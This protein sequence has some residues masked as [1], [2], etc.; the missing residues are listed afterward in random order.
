M[1]MKKSVNM[2]WIAAAVAGMTVLSGTAM[3]AFADVPE[4]IWEYVQLEDEDDNI[5]YDFKEVE[6]AVPQDWEGKYKFETSENQDGTGSSVTFYHPASREAREKEL[7]Y[8][9]EGGVLFSVCYSENYDFLDVLPSYQ[10]IGSGEKGV[11]YL[12]F[13]TDVQGYLD[14]GKIWAEWETLT[15]DY[16]WIEARAQM[17]APGEGIVD[18]DK[19][20]EQDAPSGDS[21]AAGSSEYIVADSSSRE[22]RASELKGMNADQLQMAINEIYA[23]HGRKFATKSIQKYFDAKSWYTGKIEPSKFDES[24]LSLTEGKNIALMLDCMKTAGTGSTSGS[25]GMGVSDSGSSGQGTAASGTQMTATTTVNIRSKASTS[26]AVMGVVPQGYVVTVTGNEENGWLPVNYAGIKGYIKQDYLSTASVGDNNNGIPQNQGNS[27]TQTNQQNTEDGKSWYASG[28]VRSAQ[29]GEVTIIEEDGSAGVYRYDS[30]GLP[31]AA[32]MEAKL[33][34][35]MKVG[36]SYNSDTWQTYAIE[37]YGMTEDTDSNLEMKWYD[38]GEVISSGDGQITIREDGGATVT[39]WCDEDTFAFA[40]GAIEAGTR[41]QI[42]YDPQTTEA[43][44]IELQ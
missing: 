36:I 42:Q 14:G 26:G 31:P 10:I 34:P 37:F 6:V 41:V 17:I 20:E 38:I 40:G 4:D 30:E 8:K 3:H 5:I 22:L 16:D 7:G 39:F 25:Q 15:D 11:Y 13:P 28:I 44:A 23:R 24:S 12:M 21:S 18:M 2:R 19:V 29:N 35:G 27:D 33:Q 1:E 32:E 43:L 9:N